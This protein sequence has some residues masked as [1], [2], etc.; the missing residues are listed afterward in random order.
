MRLSRED[1]ADARLSTGRDGYPREFF[2]PGNHEELRN[3]PRMS[4]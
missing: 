3:L 4:D 2:R 1:E